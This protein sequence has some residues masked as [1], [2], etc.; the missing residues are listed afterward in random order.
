M[1]YLT[2]VHVNLSSNIRAVPLG[3]SRQV[4]KLV[5]AKVPSLGKYD[6]ISDFLLG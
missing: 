1:L 3:L 4:K 6:D 5:Q 2:E